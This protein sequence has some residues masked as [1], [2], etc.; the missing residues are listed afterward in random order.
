M[1]TRALDDDE[2]VPDR[3]EAVLHELTSAVLFD[4]ASKPE[5]RTYSPRLII[6]RCAAEDVSGE[7]V[8]RAY[9]V[10]M[11]AASGT[12]AD[13]IVH[14]P[15]DEDY[16]RSALFYIAYQIADA[17][18]TEVAEQLPREPR[19]ICP[20]H[21]HPMWATLGRESA[22]WQCPQDPTRR[23]SLWPRSDA[24]VVRS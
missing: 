4:L 20:G 21:Q 6:T 23:R 14:A 1:G 7:L 16:L 9:R 8:Q 22:W 19:P 24:T 3:V 13:T 10:E 18:Q 15:V 12:Y 5:R 17:I 2:P 11:W